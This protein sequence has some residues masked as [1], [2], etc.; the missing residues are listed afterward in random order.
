MEGLI[1]TS[2]QA[3][4]AQRVCDIVEQS[5]DAD[6]AENIVVINLHG[7]SDV[8]DFMVI[9]SGRSQRHVQTLAE[10]LQ[11]RLKAEGYADIQMEGQETGDWVLVDSFHVVAHVFHPEVRAF[12]NLERMWDVPLPEAGAHEEVQVGQFA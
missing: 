9:A 4:E 2:R 5:L 1:D 8:A 10:H 11:E 6:K 12:Y 7:K 3:L